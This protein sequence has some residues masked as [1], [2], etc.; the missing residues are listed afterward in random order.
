MSAVRFYLTSFVFKWDQV[1]Q[2][3]STSDMI[4][5]MQFVDY[6][7]ILFILLLECLLYFDKIGF[8]GN[9]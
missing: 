4:D 9:F 7:F 5:L 3:L 8:I 6:M 1:P 2:M